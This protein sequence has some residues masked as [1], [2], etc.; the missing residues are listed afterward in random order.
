MATIDSGVIFEESTTGAGSG[1]YE[2]FL[3]VHDGPIEQGFNTDDNDDG[4]DNVEGSFT[5]SV[6]LASLQTTTVGGIDYVEFRLDLNES[7]GGNANI[8]LEQLVIYTSSA[9][10]VGGDFDENGLVAPSGFTE[11]FSLSN[12]IVLVDTNSGSGTDDYKI[13]VPVSALGG[14]GPGTYITFFSEFSGSDGGF[15]EFRALSSPAI[16]DLNLDKDIVGTDTAGNGL[17]DEAGD[18]INY[19]VQVINDGNRPLTDITL[20]DPLIANLTYV[21]GDIGD[22]SILGVGEIWLYEGSYTITQGDLDS[23]GT[24]ELGNL[25]PGFIDNTA[26]A[27]SA[28]TGP[29]SGSAAAPLVINKAL[30]IEKDGTVPGGTANVA[31]ELISYTMAVTNTGNAAIANVVVNDP[32]LTN[33]APVLVGG[34]NA[35]D[36][37]QDNLLD[38]TET[39]QFTGTHTVTQAELDSNGGGDGDIDNTAT[40]DSDQTGPDTASASVLVAQAPALDISKVAVP[41]Q[42][43]DVAGETLSY[44]I[45]VANTGNQ[46]LTGVQVSDPSAASLVRGSDQVG[47]NDALL[48]VGEV[49]RYTATHAVTQA[50]IDTN[51]G[52]D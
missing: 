40:A 22:D 46:T 21:S 32:F 12:P 50:E 41:G 2:A 51:G 47:D 27:D 35:G 33:E 42:L 19:E 16:F 17:L 15:E 38:T 25:L 34:F 5:H 6:Q 43:A 28:E 4:L 10:A 36:T 30:H 1:N 20:S 44:T 23:N 48:E 14:A 45:T 18:V 8:T 24:A 3:R 13:L 7:G 11:A 29:A 52:G 31:G 9:P 39:W 49:W 26:T 37:D